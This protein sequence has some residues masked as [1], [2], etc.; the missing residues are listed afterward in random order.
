[1]G[2]T[3]VTISIIADDLTGACDT[4]CLFAGPGP[5][6]VVAEPALPSSDR[7]IVTVDT[8]S[9]A[10]PPAD[11]R[12]VITAVAA[13][14]ER[15]LA[16]GLTFKKIDSTMRGAVGTELAA[17]L[18]GGPFTGA[19]VCPAFPAQRRVVRHGRLLVD[20]VPVHESPI[21][22][23]PD[24]R[25]ATADM[26]ALL[27][28]AGAP[29]VGLTLDEV[30]AGR[31]KITHVLEQNPGAIISADAETDAD[32]AALAEALVA[33]SGALAV[34]SAGLGGA[35]SRVLGAAG[36]APA[37]PP[38]TARLVVVGSRHPASRAQLAALARAGVPCVEAD[39][40]GHGDPAPAVAALA[41]GRPACV[42]S[43]S[44][45]TADRGAVARHVARAVAAIVGRAR[46][47]LGVVTGG[48]TAYA[49]LQALRPERLDLRGAPA[50]GLALGDLTMR[51]GRRVPLLTKA[52]GFDAAPLFA[53]VPEGTR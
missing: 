36:P 18:G 40:A 50:D 25:A 2:S 24:F 30:R 13:R 22:R 53:A 49:L 11:A 21:T 51:D 27:G 1:M 38:G 17:L 9:R 33:A 29:V 19:L 12:R 31:E 10:L 3:A 20:S 32:L 45:E 14:L 35:L 43:A 6:G 42:A 48:E 37:L 44:A 16:G 5:V 47:D 4:G 41:A 15:R 28:A 8:E 52:G 39:A 34:G 46:P 26:S 7:A 23:D